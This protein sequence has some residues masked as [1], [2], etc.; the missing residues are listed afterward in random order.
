VLLETAEVYTQR[1]D[2]GGQICELELPCSSVTAESVV[3]P[4]AAGVR[5]KLAPGY[6]SL[7]PPAELTL[8]VP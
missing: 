7:C 8:T 3:C 6:L 1:V 2:L 5:L 4:W